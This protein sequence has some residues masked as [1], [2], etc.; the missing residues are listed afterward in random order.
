[1]WVSSFGSLQS[2]GES[3]ANL[4]S[5]DSAGFLAAA[6][7]FPDVGVDWIVAAAQGD[8]LDWACRTV[9]EQYSGRQSAYGSIC[10]R[11]G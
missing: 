8:Y 3:I 9:L 2:I 7:Y 6:W 4:S 11:V 10:G 1:M 5:Q